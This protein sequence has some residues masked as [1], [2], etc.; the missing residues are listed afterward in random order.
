MELFDILFT[1]IAQVEPPSVS[2]KAE[3]GLANILLWA[4]SAVSTALAGTAVFLFNSY[5]KARDNADS[6]LKAQIDDKNEQ[7]KAQKLAEKD[8]LDMS[9]KST[10]ATTTLNNTMQ[11]VLSALQGLDRRL[12]DVERKIV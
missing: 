4:L 9:N 1:I 11:N 2:P 12:E 7:L 3:D 10:A 5:K 8:L 6:A